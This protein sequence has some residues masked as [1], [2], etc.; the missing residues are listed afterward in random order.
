[1]REVRLVDDAGEQ[2]GI[3]PTRD[4]LRMAFDRQLDLVEVAPTAKPPVCRI[5]DFGKF[6]YEQSKRDREARRKQKIVTIKELKMRPNIEEHD[7]QVRLRNCQRFL[8]EGDKVKATITFRGREITHS[9]LG[10]QVLVRLAE[11]IKDLGFIEREPRV[12]GRNMVMILSA[13]EQKE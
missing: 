2:V 9:E 4:A 3:L 6:R 5:M 1:V 11:A 10:R 13:R 12:E 7:F 8:R